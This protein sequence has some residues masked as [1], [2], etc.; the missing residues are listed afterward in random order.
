ML[1]K[2]PGT[3]ALAVLALALGIG[4]TT[5]MFSIVQGAF[6]RGLAIRRVGPDHV[7]R[8]HQRDAPDEQPGHERRTTSWTGRRRSSRSSRWPPSAATVS[9]CPAAWRRSGIA[10][11][12][13]RRTCCALLR[14]APV[15][16][17][18]FTEADAQPGAPPVVL[19]SHTIWTT[20]FQR[21]SSAIGQTVRINGEP[22]QIVGVMP[23]VL[24]FRRRRTCGGRFDFSRRPT[25]NG[26]ARSRSTPSAV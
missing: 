19:I 1:L 18:D 4:L 26:A 11:R 8:P 16:G 5:T 13:S 23:D 20:Q 21:A 6:L 17:R 2:R 15:L 22:T 9:S 24:R 3:S 12:G 10:A 25:A 14:V 7:D